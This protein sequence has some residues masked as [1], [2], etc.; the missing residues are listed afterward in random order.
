MDLAV[1]T[2]Q[3]EEITLACGEVIL[4]RPME[5][6]EWGALQAWFKRRCPSPVTRALY[7]IQQAHQAGERISPD[8]QQMLLDHAQTQ[9]INW[10]P[11][12]LSPDWLAILDGV[13]GALAECLHAIISHADPLVTRERC[14]FLA[15]N[16]KPEDLGEIIRVAW[17]GGTPAVP[18]AE[19][20]ARTSRV[21]TR[22]TGGPAQTT[23]G[24]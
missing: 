22:T 9:A 19:A 12:I 14:A 15:A 18:K 23:P 21:Q 7:A 16:L 8:V 1:A 3:P 11:R 20:P 10:P 17:N 5:M 4:V 2:G 13:E 6:Q 24:G